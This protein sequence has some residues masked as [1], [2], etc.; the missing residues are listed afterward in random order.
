V[1]SEQRT[2]SRKIVK[3]KAT[4]ALEGQQPIPARTTDV[5]ANGVSLS[6]PKPL[7]VGQAAQVTF[8]L[9]VDGIATRINARS[10]V[11]YCIFGN[12]EFKVGFQ[13]LNLELASMTALARFL[14]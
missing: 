8:A 7:P 1:I 4:V 14:R 9:L 12:D 5:G 6:V 3:V 2:S 13:F 10:K 11:M